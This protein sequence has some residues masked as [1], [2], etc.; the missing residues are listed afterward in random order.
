M[1]QQKREVQYGILLRLANKKTEYI[2]NLLNGRYYLARCNM[3]AEQIQT[4]KILEKID[5][6][7]KTMDYIRAEY[8]LMKMQAIMSLRTAHFSK[9]DLLGEF[10]LTKE[11]VLA[12]EDDYYNGKIIREDYDDSYRKQHKAEFVGL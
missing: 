10:K 1:E 2:R 11:D 8:A 12:L 7:T 3:L 6:A 5:G 9:E 4:G